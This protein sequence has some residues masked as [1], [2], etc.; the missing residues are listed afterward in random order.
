[1]EILKF[2]Q[3]NKEALTFLV[4]VAGGIAVVIGGVFALLRWF[5]DQRWRRVQ[6][7]EQLVKEFFASENTKLALRMLDVQGRM[8][9]PPLKKGDKNRPVKID[10]LLLI[11]SLLT[12]EQQQRFGQPEFS[13]RMI[14]DQFFTDLS[15]FQHHIDAKLIKVRDVRPYLEYWIKGINGYGSIYSVRLAQQIHAFLNAFDYNAILKLSLS[16]GYSVKNIDKSPKTK[17]A[18]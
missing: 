16:M 5:V 2:I 9:L 1:M 7:A 18:R 4:S 14:L 17:I 12:L 11:N 8:E 10:E 6:Y 3:Q 13:I 15:M